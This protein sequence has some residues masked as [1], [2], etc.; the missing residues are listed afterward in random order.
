MFVQHSSVVY[1]RIHDE[2]CGRGYGTSLCKHCVTTKLLCGT[3]FDAGRSQC[4]CFILCRTS[5]GTRGAGAVEVS[6]LGLM[7]KAA[8]DR[9]MGCHLFLQML[10]VGADNTPVYC[11]YLLTRTM[12][13]GHLT[14]CLLLIPGSMASAGRRHF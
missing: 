3:L 5:L 8:F 4:F 13:E 9:G 7:T 12:S 2:L 14:F 11:C 6:L 1:F 10:P